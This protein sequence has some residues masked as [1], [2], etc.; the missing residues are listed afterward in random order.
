VVGP[1]VTD[2]RWAELPSLSRDEAAAERE[3]HVRLKRHFAPAR[4]VAALRDT[5]AV[6]IEGYGVAGGALVEGLPASLGADVKLASEELELAVSVEP[7]L[8]SLLL[9]RL[10]GRTP[11]LSAQSALTPPLDHAFAVLCA[12]LCRRVAP[13]APLA[14]SSKPLQG[15]LWRTDFWLRAEGAAFRGRLALALAGGPLPRGPV[16][17]G[18]LPV[19]LPLVLLAQSLPGVELGSL[20]VGD[21]VVF[22]APWPAAGPLGT[23]WLCAGANSAALQVEIT[24][25]GL[26]LRAAAQLEYEVNTMGEV[27]TTLAQGL[28]AAVLDGPVVVRLELGEVTLPARDWLAL[29]SGDVLQ[30]DLPL[31]EPVVLRV[32]GRVVGRG[33]LVNVEGRLGVRLLTV[34]PP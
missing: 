17:G 13:A 26:V 12:E 29:S 11:S 6:E 3:A 2:F 15:W 16:V 27:D 19:S 4:F 25:T 9:C 18:A 24:A 23:A 28:E 14:L 32:A 33:T 30:T 31:G 10:L 20:E 7:G 5:L 22:D 1:S 8:A 21:A 34:T